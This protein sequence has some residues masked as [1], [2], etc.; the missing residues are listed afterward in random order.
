LEKERGGR[1]AREHPRGELKG[2]KKA[3]RSCGIRHAGK[4]RGGKGGKVW[5]ERSLSKKERPLTGGVR[6]KAHRGKR[7]P[8]EVS[9][10]SFKKN[11]ERKG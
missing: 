5:E 8:L 9:N 1:C 10:N 7:N 3:E 11:I 2:G 6:R 4:K